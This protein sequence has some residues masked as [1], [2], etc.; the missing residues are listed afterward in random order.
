M[1]EFTQGLFIHSSVIASAAGPPPRGADVAQPH[2]DTS[3]FFIHSANAK[4]QEA[5][6]TTDKKK[7]K[8][9]YGFDL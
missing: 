5:K 7:D 2:T 8:I 3:K 6:T 4:A 9:F 1:N